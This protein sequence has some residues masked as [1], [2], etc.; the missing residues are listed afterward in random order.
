MFS[1]ITELQRMAN[2]VFRSFEINNVKANPRKSHVLLNSNIQRVV[3]FDNV[4][5]LSRSSETFLGITFNLGLKFE[6]NISEICN[7]GNKK[8][9][10]FQCIAN[11]KNLDKPKCF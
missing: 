10:A 3:P 6:E 9:N 11:H 1:V 2:K 4:Q 5:I 8:L 7:T